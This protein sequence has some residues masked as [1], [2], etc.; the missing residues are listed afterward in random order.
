[1]TKPSFRP[2]GDERI[3][4][5]AHRHWA[6]F[7]VRAI[8]PVLVGVSAAIVFLARSFGGQPDILGNPPPLFDPLGI[9]LLVSLLVTALI[10]W[11]IW[12][13]WRNDNLILTNKRVIREDRTLWLRD[14]DQVIPLE[15]IQNVNILRE[16]IIQHLL[17]YGRVT[18]HAAGPTAPIVLD[19]AE[20]PEEIQ[21][22]VLGEANRQK[23]S[24]EEKHLTATVERRLNPDAPP[25]PPLKP[26]IAI[27]THQGPLRT[28]L[29][30]GPIAE[31]GSI[32]WHRH[33]VVLVQHLA[34]P[35]VL[36]LVWFGLFYLLVTQAVFTPTRTI[37]ILFVSLVG[38]LFY[39]YWQ[40][41]NWHDDIYILEPTK[42]I[43]IHRRPFGLREDRR[44]ATLGV[45]Q[46]V[47]AT[48]PNIAARVLGYGNVLI[49][50]A[51]AGGNFTFDHVPHPDQVQ[52][53]VFEYRDR[54]KWQERE[55]EWN[56]VLNIV[57]MYH[58]ANH[59]GNPPLP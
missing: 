44:E 17:K 33:W 37:V 32:I 26:P 4:L 9:F 46:N 36:L 18:V 41:A 59:R 39:F 49:E 48:S 30:S 10:G 38:I 15:N 51:G 19:R 6:A 1:M 45:I 35:T 14:T 21:R 53:I 23:K 2:Q 50:T 56:N 8:V 5:V 12:V 7:A 11:Y 20:R 55:R 52:R 47:N 54:F 34:A 16:N 27:P 22:R 3:I 29:P 57:E 28:I 58:R 13:D 40:Y 43:D 42:I 24:L 31:S 25:P